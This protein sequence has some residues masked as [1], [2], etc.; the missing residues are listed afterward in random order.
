M[1]R[2]VCFNLN[3]IRSKSPALA[4]QLSS[5]FTGHPQPNFCVEA[6]KAIAAFAP[7]WQC[8][9]QIIDIALGGLDWQPRP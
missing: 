8:N 2:K 3:E 5:D 7:T 1:T 9:N 6:S 4:A